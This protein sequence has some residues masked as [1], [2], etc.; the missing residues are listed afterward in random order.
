MVS[1]TVKDN[2]LRNRSQVDLAAGETGVSFDPAFE[3]LPGGALRRTVKGAVYNFTAPTFFQANPGLLGE[4]VDEAVGSESGDVAIDLYAGVG[5]FAIQ[6]AQR[7][8][9]VIGVELDTDAA[10]FALAN[11]AANGVGNVEFKTAVVEAWMK[12]FVETT[13]PSPDLIVLD[14]PRTG[15]AGALSQIV[16]AKPRRITY[17]S[18]DP[19]TLARD[20]RKLVDSGYELI[21]VTAIDLFPQT[22]HVETVAS[23]VLR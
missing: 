16:A 5:L 21:K 19:S 2:I 18:C 9:R 8:T 22:Y 11:I 23:L 6:L 13:A 15:A 3:G 10:K 4:L 17:I 20:L 14:P 12:S 7:F 1:A